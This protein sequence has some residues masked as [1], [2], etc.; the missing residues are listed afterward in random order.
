MKSIICKAA[1][2]A[3]ALCLYCSGTAVSKPCLSSAEVFSRYSTTLTMQPLDEPTAQLLAQNSSEETN[4]DTSTWN[5][6][7][8]S[9]FKVKFPN[10]TQYK[11]NNYGGVW[12]QT[13][14][15]ET[16]EPLH[17]FKLDQAQF[18][19]GVISGNDPDEFLFGAI[20]SK[21]KEINGQ[22]TQKRRIQN[23]R[24]PGCFFQIKTNDAEW[25]YMIRLDGDTVYTLSVC[26]MP[27]EAD[28]GYSKAFF[29]SL[30]F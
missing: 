6:I 16:D 9:G 24:Y 15:A 23:E 21:C 17:M 5:T 1:L 10:D 20:Q 12:V 22:V 14:E 27:Y 13:W 18:S 8:G 11:R 25:E 29:N 19:N 7:S 30:S 2:A 26:S 28:D 3:G 4:I